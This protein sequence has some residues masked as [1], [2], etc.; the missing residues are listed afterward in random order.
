[1]HRWELNRNDRL[2]VKSKVSQHA[3][4]VAYQLMRKNQSARNYSQAYYEPFNG[5]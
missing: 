2:S 1:M 5:E 4:A 3:T